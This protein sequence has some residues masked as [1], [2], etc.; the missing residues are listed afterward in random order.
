[1]AH[2]APPNGSS[3]TDPFTV[4][5]LPDTILEGETAKVRLRLSLP[6]QRPAWI[7]LHEL[8][9]SPTGCP[10]KQCKTERLNDQ[11]ADHDHARLELAFRVP[12]G[13]VACV[14]RLMAVWLGEL[15]ENEEVIRRC[16]GRVKVQRG[17]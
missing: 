12:S 4:D 6:A 7:E 11:D 10:G 15:D 13:L 5:E 8:D 2:I 17:G 16:L 3:T 1:M 9:C 14:W